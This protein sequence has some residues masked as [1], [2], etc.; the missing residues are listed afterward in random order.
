[1]KRIYNCIA[2]L[3]IPMILT[4]C[5]KDDDIIGPDSPGA[6][7]NV[8]EFKDIVAPSSSVGAPFPLF[9]PSTLD[10]EVSEVTINAAIKFAGVDVAPEDITVEIG[11]DNEIVTTYNSSQKSNYTALSST[12]FEIPSSVVIK[13]GEREAVV[14][15]K[16]F[17]NNFDPL[18]EN[19]LPLVIKSTSSSFP[20]SGNYGK[21][22]YSFP[23]KSIWEGTYTYT[24][25]NDFGTIDANIGGSFTEEGVKLS[26][27]GPNKLYVDY[28]WRTYSGHTHYQF[29][30]DNTS[31]TSITAYSGSDRPAT[32]NEIIVV[33]PEN[34]IF[35]V[36]WTAIG[37]GVTERFVRTGD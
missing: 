32:I 35:E 29:N 1:M 36:K 28:L 19:V 34:M 23:I 16:L 12:S 21:V 26:T 24:V 31:L 25:T 3:I 11:V 8:I 33:D 9:V 18:K 27:I 13:K 37:R 22:I 4:S 7:K 17:T 15:I 2:I 30:G 14:S 20:I 10:P 6:F 5:L